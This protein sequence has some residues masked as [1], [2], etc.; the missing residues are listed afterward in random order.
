MLVAGSWVG[1]TFSK[2]FRSFAAS[3]K[4]AGGEQS[5]ATLRDLCCAT[6]KQ[7]I[8]GEVEEAAA[9]AAFERYVEEVL[10]PHLRVGQIVIMDTLNCHKESQ[11]RQLLEARGCQMLFFPAY[12]PD[13]SPIG[14]EL[15]RP[16]CTS[17]PPAPPASRAIWVKQKALLP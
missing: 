3:C 6:L 16:Q 8:E 15:F 2:S 14:I 7:I 1:W 10:S 5:I 13:F 9:L 11:V 12:S 17:R 4:R